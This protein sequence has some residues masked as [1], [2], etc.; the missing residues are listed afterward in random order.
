[1]SGKGIL[2][3]QAFAEMLILN[4]NI[5]PLHKNVFEDIS[6][7]PDSATHL[8][9]IRNIQYTNSLQTLDEFFNDILFS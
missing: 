7:S 3:Y 1:M 4:A 6:Q 8:T 2:D 5:K 9:T